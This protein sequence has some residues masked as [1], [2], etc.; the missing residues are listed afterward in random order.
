[1]TCKQV[2]KLQEGEKILVHVNK[3]NQLIKAAGNLCKRFMTLLLKEPK[4]CP[5]DF[6]DWTECK[7]CCGVRI[8]LELQYHCQLRFSYL[9]GNL[10]TILNELNEA[11]NIV[12]DGEQE[13]DYTEDDLLQALDLIEAPKY[14]MDHQWQMFK[15]HLRTPAAKVDYVCIFCRGGNEPSRL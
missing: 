14:F 1:M 8:L 11:D 4:L 2:Y 3:N 10:W 5:P 7:T 13:M 6:K 9:K 15:S 12:E